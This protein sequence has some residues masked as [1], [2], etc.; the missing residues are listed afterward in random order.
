MID[1]IARLGDTVRF[2]DLEAEAMNVE[3]IRVQV[4]TPATLCRMKQDTVRSI[5]R[6]AHHGIFPLAEDEA[7]RPGGSQVYVSGL[8]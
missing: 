2:E 4:D 8:H 7:S 5:D 3:G 1:L 6:Q